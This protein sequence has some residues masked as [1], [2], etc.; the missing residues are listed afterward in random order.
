[1]L[2][3]KDQGSKWIVMPSLCLSQQ[4]LIAKIAAKAIAESNIS[5]SIICVEHNVLFCTVRMDVYFLKCGGLR[6]IQKYYM[7][8]LCCLWYK[9]RVSYPFQIQNVY[10]CKF[11]HHIPWGDRQ[12]RNCSRYA[13][14]VR[15]YNIRAWEFL[16]LWFNMHLSCS[17]TQEFLLY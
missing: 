1:M 7:L 10:L 17:Y 15:N 11:L 12:N 14:P 6:E 13:L 9:I 3:H 16:F 5:W 4:L 2:S 8:H